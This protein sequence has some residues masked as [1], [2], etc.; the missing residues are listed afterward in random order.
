MATCLLVGLATNHALHACTTFCMTSGG[1][2]LFGRNYDFDF[3]RGVLLAN[4]RGLLKTGFATNGPTWTARHGSVTFNQFGRGFPMGGINEAGLVV[5]LMWHEKAEYPA[6]DQRGAVG[7][8]EWIQYQLDTASTVDEVIASD[9]RVRI[10]GGTPLHYLVADRSG[11]AA[12][13]EFLGGRLLPHTGDRLPVSVLANDSYAESLAF[14]R[15]RNGR[16]AGGSGSHERFARAA[17]ALSTVKRGE[18]ASV[19]RAF[20]VLQ[21]VAQKST[22]WS[23]VYDQTQRVV[24]FRTDQHAAVRSVRLDGLPFGCGEGVKGIDVHAPVAGDITAALGDFSEAQNRELVTKSYAEF[25]GT[26]HAPR[27]EIERTAAHPWQAGCGS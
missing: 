1:S 10:Q 26:R 16:R 2:V 12:T 14:W 8:L 15:G 7:V 3:G 13:I 5:E 23:I 11:R 27:E 22:R 20:A 17:D 4:P 19:D 9:G 25:S 6:P 21:D 18:P 24:H